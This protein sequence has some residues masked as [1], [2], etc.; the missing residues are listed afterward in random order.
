MTRHNFFER[1]ERE[2]DIQFEYEKIENIVLNEL[3]GYSTIN[4]D[5]EE[6]FSQ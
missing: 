5:I 1:L 3:D 6:S 4:E 2:L